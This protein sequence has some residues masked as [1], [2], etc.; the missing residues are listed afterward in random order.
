MTDFR[1]DLF[2]LISE[3]RS[4]TGAL[5]LSDWFNR[6]AIIE[7]NDNYDSLTRGLCRV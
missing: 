6:P 4:S 3:I 1:T 2:S 7:A 5:R